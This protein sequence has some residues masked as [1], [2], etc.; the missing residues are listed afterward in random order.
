MLG[1]VIVDYDDLEYNNDTIRDFKVKNFGTD[2]V[3]LHTKEMIRGE[4]A[5]HF[6]SK[7][8]EMEDFYN[9]LNL[10]MSKLRYKSLACIIDKNKHLDRYK[11]NAFD[12]YALSLNI[13]VER[14]VYALDNKETGLIKVEAR[15][16]IQDKQIE[17]EFE[18]IQ[19]IGT[20]YIKAREITRKIEGFKIHKKLENLNGL[21]M[22]D[23]VVS[24]FG[25]QYLNRKN[26]TVKY[27]IVANSIITRAT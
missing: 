19:N 23:L 26:N 20:S 25:R 6:L 15:G 18:K 1:G 27:E 17:L 2:N 12:V 4:G 9:N 8:E 16:K 21:Q 7:R 14:F 13:L 22:A 3:I 5:F 11:G 24:P 10:L